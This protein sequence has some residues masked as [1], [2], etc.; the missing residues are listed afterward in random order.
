M[1]KKTSIFKNI[2]RINIPMKEFYFEIQKKFRSRQIS[3][4]KNSGRPKSNTKG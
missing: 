1:E 3:D 4:L 2:I